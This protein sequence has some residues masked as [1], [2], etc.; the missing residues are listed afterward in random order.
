MAAGCVPAQHMQSFTVIS[1]VW[2]GVCLCGKACLYAFGLCSKQAHRHTL[3]AHVDM[4]CDDA[5][6][7]APCRLWFDVANNAFTL[8][9][10]LQPL[11][12]FG[13]FTTQFA[14]VAVSRSIDLSNNQITAPLP[15]FMLTA[16]PQIA[17]LCRCEMWVVLSGGAN[18]IRCPAK[19]PLQDAALRTFRALGMTCTDPASGWLVEVVSALVAGPGAGMVVPRALENVT[20]AQ[21]LSSVVPPLNGAGQ[22]VL[23]TPTPAKKGK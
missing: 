23:S 8:S 12:N 15:Q 13:M 20:Y 6:M 19:T 17:S 22:L 4:Q 10:T 18:N 16:V 3:Q 7:L 1:S 2:Q 21:L 5:C 9:G 11:A 14:M